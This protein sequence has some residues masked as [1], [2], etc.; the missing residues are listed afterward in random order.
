[1]TAQTL[2]R[3]YPKIYMW[4]LTFAAVQTD[5][6]GSKLFSAFLNHLRQVVGRTGWGGLRVVELHRE[7]GIHYHLLVTERLAVDLVRRIGRCYGIGRIHVCRA[8]PH[9]AAYLA[10]Y[11]SK[12]KKG[13]I[14]QSGRNMRRWAAF[15][16]VPRTRIKDLINESPMWLY[17]RQNTLPFLSYRHEIFLWSIWDLHDPQTFKAAYYLAKSDRETNGHDRHTQDIAKLLTRQLQARGYL[18]R[19]PKWSPQPF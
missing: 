1:M 10:K 12:Q 7:H 2:F 16:D 4:T 5:W 13:P 19:S 8:Q 3:E 15:G 18:V 11:L 6:E 9:S 14:T 17:R